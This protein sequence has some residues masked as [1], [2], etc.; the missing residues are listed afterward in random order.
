MNFKNFNPKQRGKPYS[1]SG[2]LGTYAAVGKSISDAAEYVTTAYT[3]AL[4]VKHGYQ[5]VR[6]ISEGN[7]KETMKTV[8]AIGGDYAASYA[9]STVGGYV[10]GM[11]GSV[12]G[13][14]GAIPGAAVG[15]AVGGWFGGE[16]ASYI[17]EE[18]VR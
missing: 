11:I 13:G 6:A 10:G 16:A 8:A 1:H 5:L 18:I 3:T 7:P 14:V 17:A 9:G 15:S 12:F 2:V 4:Y